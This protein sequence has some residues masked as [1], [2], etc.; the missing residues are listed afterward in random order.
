MFEQN[1]NSLERLWEA[2]SPDPCLY[3][4]RKE[5]NWLCG[6]LIAYRRRQRGSKDTYGELAA[7]TRELIQ[8]NTVRFARSPSLC[9]CSRST[10]ITPNVWMIFHPRPTKPRHSKPR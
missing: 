4:H 3:P 8:Q 1:F 7:K 9:P 6:V 2:I 10:K 5:Y